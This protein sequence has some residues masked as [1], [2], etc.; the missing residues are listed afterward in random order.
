MLGL[1]RFPPRPPRILKTL[2]VAHRIPSVSRGLAPFPLG[3]PN[4]PRLEPSI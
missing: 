1:G 3:F 4:S 2:E